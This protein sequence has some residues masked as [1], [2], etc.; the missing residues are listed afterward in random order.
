MTTSKVSRLDQPVPYSITP[1]GQKYLAR[2]QREIQKRAAARFTTFL[3][4]D[5]MV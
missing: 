1:K 3:R 5:G 4:L 2:K